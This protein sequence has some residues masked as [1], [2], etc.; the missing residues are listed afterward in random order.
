MIYYK[1]AVKK[2]YKTKKTKHWNT[3]NEIAKDINFDCEVH[4]NYKKSHKRLLAGGGNL[5]WLLGPSHD[6]VSIRTSGTPR[7]FDLFYVIS[8]RP[9]AVEFIARVC[10]HN[11]RGHVCAYIY[12]ICHWRPQCMVGTRSVVWMHGR[13]I[14]S[15]TS[16]VIVSHT[17][18]AEC[19]LYAIIVILF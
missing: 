3:R 14:D 7:N 8:P 15:L 13:L 2:T 18:V 12:K 11:A 4:K 19:H 10:P 6:D 1:K 9:P 17:F 16:Q 5:G